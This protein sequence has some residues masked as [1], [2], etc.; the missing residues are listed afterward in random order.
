MQ[1]G[2]GSGDVDTSE[3]VEAGT[4]GTLTA[5]CWGDDVEVQVNKDWQN[6]T[7]RGPAPN[8]FAN[9][10]ACTHVSANPPSIASPQKLW[11]S[12][13]GCGGRFQHPKAHACDW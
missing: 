9:I 2:T 12:A 7:G 3:V 5:A 11:T 8:V 6:P 4:G 10:H 1:D 13:T